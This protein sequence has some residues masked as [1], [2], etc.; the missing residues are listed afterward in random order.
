MKARI[1]TRRR[2]NNEIYTVAHT[3][4]DIDTPHMPHQSA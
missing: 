4:Q 3:P 2:W 1:P